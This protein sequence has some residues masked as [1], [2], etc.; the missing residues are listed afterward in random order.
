MTVSRLLRAIGWC[1]LHCSHR[2]PSNRRTCLGFRRR[3]QHLSQEPSQAV[4]KFNR[5]TEIAA[6]TVFALLGVALSGCTSQP[7]RPAPTRVV[8]SYLNAIAEGDATRAAKLDAAAVQNR[9]PPE[10]LAA[11]YGDLDSLRTDVVLQNAVK[12]ITQVSVDPNSAE[13]TGEEGLVAVHY[14]YELDGK[15]RN[16]SLRVRW[17]AKTNSW[18]LDETLA[19]LW[20]QRS[21]RRVP[22]PELPSFGLMELRTGSF[23]MQK[24]CQ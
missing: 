18:Y 13:N 19:V 6:S 9:Y 15:S 14:E 5:A 4:H 22:S 17:N 21:K 12:R 10:S 11:Q 24:G 23:P 20:F 7:T 3:S 1:G 2:W 8:L 16:S